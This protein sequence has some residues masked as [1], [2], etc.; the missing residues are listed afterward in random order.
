MPILALSMYL[1]LTSYIISLFGW[2]SEV[3]S[4]SDHW[5]EG[6]MVLCNVPLPIDI[7]HLGSNV[8]AIGDIDKIDSPLL[9]SLWPVETEPKSSICA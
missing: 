7:I 9:R 1:D 2:Y 8:F 6:E 5:E 4:I 3:D